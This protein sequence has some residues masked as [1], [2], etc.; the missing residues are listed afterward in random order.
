MDATQVRTQVEQLWHTRPVRPTSPRTVAG[1]CSGI[2]FRYRIDPT[3]VKV[4]F[5]VSTLFGGS[6]LLLYVVG[7]VAFPSSRVSAGGTDWRRSGR[8]GHHNPALVIIAAVVI[9]VVVSFGPHGT[10]SSGAVLGTV[11]MLLGWWLLF[12]RAPTPLPGT[13]ADTLAAGSAPAVEQFQ[14]WTPR[15]V[16]AEASPP[17]ASDATVSTAAAVSSGSPATPSLNKSAVAD[18][19]SAPRRD[20]PA[21]VTTVF[22]S[23]D[24]QPPSWDPLGAARF[25]WDLPE[26]A[27]PTPPAEPTSRGSA[28]RASLVI[29]G[30]ALLVAMSGVAAHQAGVDWFT[31]TRILALALAVVGAGLLA[32]AALRRPTG[33]RQV[34]LVPVAVVLGAAVVIAAAST[35]IATDSGFSGVP[36][37]GVGQR[38]HKPLSEHDL[39]D[40]YSVTMG[41][42]DLDVRAITLTSDRT[43]DLEAG[44]GQ[45]TVWVP[46]NMNV[47]ANC[48][49]NVGDTHCPEGLSVGTAGADKPVLTLNVHNN[50]GDVEVTR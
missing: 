16:R 40:K 29:I 36:E 4:A 17:I 19:S 22:T 9:I 3:L 47:R 43:V 18:V 8:S 50:M 31:P 27:T 48:T 25:A 49:T 28:T 20:D 24:R 7:W 33:R 13:S 1:V 30:A 12:R 34:G 44:L 38:T 42:L 6:G 10:W 26:P 46:K 35:S 23:A 32:L 15:A 2:A 14:R 11:L 5:V 21:A 37:G 45:V 41:E 39:R